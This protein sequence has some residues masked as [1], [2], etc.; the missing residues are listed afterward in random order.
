MKSTVHSIQ[1]D[2]GGITCCTWLTTFI[3]VELHD[4]PGLLYYSGRI[5]CC[6]W[7]TIFIVVELH[8]LPGLLYYCNRHPLLSDPTPPILLALS[9]ARQI[10]CTCSCKWLY[11]NSEQRI[12]SSQP[13]LFQWEVLAATRV[14]EFNSHLGF[15]V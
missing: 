10:R 14:A 5:T 9:T 3:V 12:Q 6:T 11:P 15:A 2:S 13:H 8:A 1:Y 4:V 7:L